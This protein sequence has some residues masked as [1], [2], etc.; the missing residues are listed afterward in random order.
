[1]SKRRGDLSSKLQSAFNALE[2]FYHKKHRMPSY[3]ELTKILKLK[4]KDSAWKIVQKLISA[5]KINKDS[6]GKLIPKQ[7]SIK[8]DRKIS[9]NGSE[10]IKLLGLIE[11]GFG[12]PAEENDL[13]TISLNS[14]LT[15]DDTST[16]MLKVKGDSMIEAG[17]NPGDY[18]IVKRTKT[19][20][21]G[22]I[23][24][25]EIDGS[26]TLKY[27]RKDTLGYFLEPANSSYTNLRPKEELKI[28]AILK[29][30]V[31]KYE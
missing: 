10:G 17:I 1:M 18:C 13:D 19:A 20:R 28:E 2:D 26:W 29:A 30:V 23:V 12:S 3:G 7:V 21:V 11:A 4:S 24:V 31:R 8:K 15:D 27:L 22:Q 14:W 25:A 9:E 5:Q 16:F 6:V